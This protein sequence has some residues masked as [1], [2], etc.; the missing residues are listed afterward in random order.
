M[1]QY[2]Y[3]LPAGRGQWEVRTAG[4]EPLFYRRKAHAMIAARAIAIAYSRELQPHDRKGR[5]QD[6]NSYGNDPRERRG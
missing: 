1:I 2:V 4:V 6:P 3:V 5:I